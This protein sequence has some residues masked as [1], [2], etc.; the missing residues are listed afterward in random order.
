MPATPGSLYPGVVMLA[1]CVLACH[2]GAA[3]SPPANPEDGRVANEAYTNDY[4]GLSYPLPPDWVEG[5]AGPPPSHSGSYVLA[6]LVPKGERPGTILIGAQDA[7]FAIKPF[8]DASAMAMEFA[9]EMAKIPGMTIDRGPAAMRIAGRDF[10][11]VDFS[12]IGLYRA[13]LV[14]ER[15]C[16]LVSFSLM[17]RDPAELASLAASLERLSFAAEHESSVPVCMK[18][19]AVGENVLHK[20][21]P[22]TAGP[23][24]TPIPVRIVVGSD[25]GVEHVHVIRATAEQ[26]KNIEDAV[27]QWRLKPYEVSG[28]AVALET[29][30]MFEFKPTN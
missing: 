18:D 21:E 24:F 3:V 26:R 28:H 6:T 2:R 22:A 5:L 19:Y 9:R 1:V 13:M 23:R 15:R 27:R 11:R 4:F 14:T 20:V 12:G 29:G 30:L 8:A 25:G 10:S 7:F 16:H 17:T